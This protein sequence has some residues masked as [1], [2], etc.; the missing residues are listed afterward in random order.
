[1]AR[2]GGAISEVTRE[3]TSVW[4]IGEGEQGFKELL[5]ITGPPL[6]ARSAF[7]SEIKR[8]TEAE[9]RN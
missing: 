3:G 6:G 8:E 4:G 7:E 5:L 9:L 2:G 1:M